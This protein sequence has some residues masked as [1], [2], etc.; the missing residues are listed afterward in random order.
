[1]IK[2]EALESHEG[3]LGLLAMALMSKSVRGDEARRLRHLVEAGLPFAEW[4]ATR[5]DVLRQIESM[6]A[7]QIASLLAESDLPEATRAFLAETA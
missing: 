7:S 4:L 5:P 2:F 1:M 3:R 6:D